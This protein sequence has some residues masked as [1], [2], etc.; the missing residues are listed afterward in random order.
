M[1]FQPTVVL[2][3][4]IVSIDKNGEGLFVLQGESGRVHLSRTVIVAVG[5][6]IVTPQKLDVEGAEKLEDANL[7][8]AIR[9]LK[10]FKDISGESPFDRRRLPGRYQCRQSGKAVLATGYAALGLGFF[11]QRTVRGA[12]SPLARAIAHHLS[13]CPIKS[14]K[15]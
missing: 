9:S 10:H 4:K 1:T 8:Y 6:G 14:R 15:P 2:N 11:P 7:H 3:E 12:E 13:G 5:G